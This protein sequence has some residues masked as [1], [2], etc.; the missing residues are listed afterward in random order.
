MAEPITEFVGVYDADSTMLGE[1]GYWLGA[2]LGIRHCS[3]CEITH[4]LFTE[5]N[6]WKQCRESLSVPFITFHRNDAPM[7]VLA[8]AKGVFPAVFARRTDQVTPVLGP[9]DL[10]A[11]DG[12][13][14]ALATRLNMIVS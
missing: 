9:T 8:A 4:G 5:R 12:S 6:D 2:R 11:L 7:D 13:P 14:E 10:E 3:L 1:V